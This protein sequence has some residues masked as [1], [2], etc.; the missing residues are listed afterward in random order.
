MKHAA[1]VQAVFLLLGIS[2]KQVHRQT[3]PRNT[4]GKTIAR[5]REPRGPLL[6][7]SAAYHADQ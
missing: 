5:W 1:S 7:Q 3:R 6:L 2:S 4:D